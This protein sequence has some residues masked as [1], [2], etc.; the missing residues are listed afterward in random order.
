MRQDSCR[1]KYDKIIWV[2]LGQHPNLAR[3]Q[4]MM[5]VQLNGDRFAD[6][7]SADQKKEELNVAMTGRSIL[8]VL[9]DAWEPE[10]IAV[11]VTP[12]HRPLASCYSHLRAPQLLDVIDDTTS[13]RVLLS[14][15]VRGLLERTDD[16]VDVG[17]PTE[18]EAVSM[19]LS[20]AGMKLDTTP[21]EA[22]AIVKFC[23]LLP[24]AIGIAVRLT[25][26]IS[27]CCGDFRMADVDS[28]RRA[29]SSL[30]LDWSRTTAGRA[31]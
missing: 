27:I 22:L 23:N 7:M 11:R 13:S 25:A 10:H 2:P 19:L 5:L 18:D 30:D 21:P 8:L 4:E 6:G 31:F 12:I 29:S 20:T 16:I 1:S 26:S 3:C 17:L 15:R 24:L 28:F 9:D 14:S